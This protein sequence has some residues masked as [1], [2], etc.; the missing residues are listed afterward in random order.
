M[1]YFSI[2]KVKYYNAVILGFT[3]L[4]FEVHKTKLEP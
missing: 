2:D 3:G 4:T 1:Y